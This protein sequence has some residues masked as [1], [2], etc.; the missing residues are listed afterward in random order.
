MD[1]LPYKKFD[2]ES[3]MDLFCINT[4]FKCILCIKKDDCTHQAFI[5]TNCCHKR[6]SEEIHHVEIQ[7]VNY[8]A[9]K[10]TR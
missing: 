7:Y 3:N 6:S 4:N 9:R 8:K 5:K 10:Q 1:K 2:V